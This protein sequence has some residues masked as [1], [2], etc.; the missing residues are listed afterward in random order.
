MNTSNIAS[1][2]SE[3][4]FTA[5]NAL[6]S[7]KHR[8]EAAVPMEIESKEEE[9]GEEREADLNGAPS[10]SLYKTFWNLQTY[11]CAPLAKPDSV[12]N[13]VG[14]EA[15][16][17]SSFVRDVNIVLEAFE[18]IKFPETQEGGEDVAS[19]T[20]ESSYIGSKYLTSSQLFSAE[21]KD[22]I[23]R[24]Q[25]LTQIL[26]YIKYLR[27]R[28]CEL[29]Y[30]KLPLPPKDI[31][32]LFRSLE[33]VEK[34]ANKLLGEV[35]PYGTKA[36]AFLKNLLERE[37][38][39]IR[40]K[41]TKPAPCPEFVRPRAANLKRSSSSS[42]S[43]SSFA[44]NV[45]GAIV[46]KRNK[47]QPATP[48]TA[49]FFDNS[50]AGVINASRKLL[51]GVPSYEEHIQA[52]LEAEDPDAGIDDEYHPKHDS[53]YCWRARR[54]LAAKDITLFEHMPDGDLS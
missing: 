4:E 41:A 13:I 26:C 9:D 34:H 54:L 20:S 11:L 43:S 33:D 7:G 50:D 51:E 22:P 19:T 52:Y 27:S 39:W 31:M 35:P 42:S 30:E 38:M 6:Y 47:S 53:V 18:R 10:Y 28:P 44:E 48:A 40:W 29:K 21:L 17:V 45:I 16:T 25:V 36:S 49:Y 3:E 15:N 8:L 14:I 23:M 24:I 32:A 12:T 37:V 46:A 1:F 2:E 5:N